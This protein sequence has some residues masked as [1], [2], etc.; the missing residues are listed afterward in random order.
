[1]IIMVDI[2]KKLQNISKYYLFILN[3]NNNKV[4]FVDKNNNKK[5]IF[6]T[7]KNKIKKNYENYSIILITIKKVEYDENQAI[8]MIFGPIK[9]EIK[10]FVFSKRG[11]IST[12]KSEKRNNHLFYT[13]SFLEK[14]KIS[15]KDLRKI[16]QLASE[17]KLEKRLLAPK[18]IEQ[19]FKK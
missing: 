12:E 1:M 19:I 11:A 8:K 10:F 7:L 18:I 3:K 13:N 4:L 17:N 2:K 16:V 9:V 6:T 15:K 14:N 5:E